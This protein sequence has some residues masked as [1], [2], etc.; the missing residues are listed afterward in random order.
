MHVLDPMKLKSSL[1]KETKDE[2]FISGKFFFRSR[3][4]SEEKNKIE[5]SFCVAAK[6]NVIKCKNKTN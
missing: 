5:K 2:I 3:I 4:L 1:E 6:R